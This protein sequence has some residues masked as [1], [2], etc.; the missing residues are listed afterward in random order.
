MASS[1]AISMLKALI[2]DKIDSLIEGKS[3]GRSSI[4]DCAAVG[5]SMQPSSGLSI[6]FMNFTH[7]WDWDWVWG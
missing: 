1:I 4:L 5:F 6:L 7:G 3:V 2:I